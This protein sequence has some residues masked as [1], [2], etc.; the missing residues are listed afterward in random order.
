MLEQTAGRKC[1]CNGLP[2]TVGLGQARANGLAELPLVTAGDDVACLAEFLSPGCDSYSA[3][4]VIGRL[5]S[6][7]E[8]AS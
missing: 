4:D 8:P 2:S 5:L 1:V 6:G 7:R 3:A